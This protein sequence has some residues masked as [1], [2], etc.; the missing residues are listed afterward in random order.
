MKLHFDI[1]KKGKNSTQVA[2]TYLLFFFYR[3]TTY[4]RFFTPAYFFKLASKQSALSNYVLTA[5]D[6]DRY[7][8]FFNV[9]IVV[10]IVQ[11]MCCNEKSSHLPK[12]LP[13][14]KSLFSQTL[15][16]RLEWKM[17]YLPMRSCWSNTIDHST[18]ASSE[19]LGQE[20]IQ[21][22]VDAGVTIGE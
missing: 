12:R 13:H 10:S 18:K 22:G 15:T 19:R 11:R 8:S 17:F 20:S 9:R 2:F 7:Q 6:K 16:I 1:A 21:N 5:A 14:V 3:M 4:W